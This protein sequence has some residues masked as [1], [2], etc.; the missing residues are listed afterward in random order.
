MDYAERVAMQNNMDI[1]EDDSSSPK[2]NTQV[3]DRSNQEDP[4]PAL[5]LMSTALPYSANQPADPS[6]CNGNFGSV[7]LFG[8]KECLDGDIRNIACSFSRISTF[9]NQRTLK[10]E[11]IEIPSQIKPIGQVAWELFETI[12]SSGWSSL[13]TNNGMSLSDRISQ[14][15][16]G[17][18][19]YTSS[20]MTNPPSKVKRIPPP[21]PPRPSKEVLEKSKHSQWKNEKKTFAQVTKNAENI[22]RIKEA[23]PSLPSNKIIQIHNAAFPSPPQ[24]RRMQITTKGPSRKQAIIP[25]NPE[26]IQIIMK[27]ANSHVGLINVQLRNI[28]SSTRAECFRPNSNNISITTSAVPSESDFITIFKY[29]KSID[30]ANIDTNSTPRAP[31]SKSYLKITGIPF[32][33][34]DG[35]PL[36]SL[37]MANYLSN[38][39]LFD[40]ISFASK[41]R[42]I[43]ASPKSDMAIVWIDIWD[44]QNGTK[45][46]TLINHSFN[47]GRYI[48]ITRGTNMNPGVPQCHN[49]WKWGHSTFACRAHGAKCQKCSGPYKLEHHRDLAWCC[50][51]NEKN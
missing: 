48:A 38:V 46:K 43:K 49:C 12:A 44:F 21:I 13:P 3:L 27:D 32:V 39:S 25:L 50:K 6:L 37:S 30:G 18:G 1:V 16:S 36:D 22:L 14:L 19:S 31:Q 7:S 15:Y 9:T 47:C 10:D 42:V 45:A 40:N 2:T 8:T 51:A 23:F 5:N 20:I 34:P 17:Q 28:K 29:F 41:P 11:N 35:L 24:K 26:Q 4:M 33:K